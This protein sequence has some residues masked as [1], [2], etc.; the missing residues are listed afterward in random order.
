[1]VE[2]GFFNIYLNDEEQSV[3][4]QIWD[5]AG[6]EAFRSVN[7]IFYRG[8]HL[9]ILAYDITNAATFE[10][11]GSWLKEVQEHCPDDVKIYLVGNK[12]ELTDKR[13]VTTEEALEFARKNKIHKAFEASA[14]TGANVRDWFAVMAKDLYMMEMDEMGAAAHSQS[15]S[16]GMSKKKN[17]V[18]EQ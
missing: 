7:R 16:I 14:K 17:S 2:F 6:Q 5:T 3:R 18:N 9:V 1:M 15:V 10:D 13:Q 8:A 11:M 4:L 12:S